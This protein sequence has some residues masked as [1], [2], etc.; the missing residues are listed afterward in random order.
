MAEHKGKNQK[1]N[2][3]EEQRNGTLEASRKSGIWEKKK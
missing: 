3:M 2:K 1:E